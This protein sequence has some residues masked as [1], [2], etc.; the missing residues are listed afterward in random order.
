MVDWFARLA[1]PALDLGQFLLGAEV[2]SV[3]HDPSLSRR[4]V[5]VVEV[6]ACSGVEPGAGRAPEVRHEILIVG[7]PGLRGVHHRPSSS[8][9]PFPGPLATESTRRIGERPDSRRRIGQLGAR[10]ARSRQLGQP[11]PPGR[12]RAPPGRTG[13]AFRL[14]EASARRR[15]V[16]A[17][18]SNRV[19][20]VGGRTRPPLKRSRAT[21]SDSTPRSR[22]RGRAAGGED[23][24]QIPWPNGRALPVAGEEPA[25][26]VPR[27]GS[28]RRQGAADPGAPRDHHRLARHLAPWSGA[29]G[30]K[31]S[32]ALPIPDCPRS[33]RRAPRRC[34]ARRSAPAPDR[35][36]LGAPRAAEAL[37]ATP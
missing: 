28:G 29:L 14:L 24:G 12:A 8:S 9:G 2:G 21:S 4:P 30:D 17:G 16:D 10:R 23:R 13:R 27:P 26:S 1:A 20:P 31:V 34:P 22:C 18:R 32:E 11:L 36:M 3:E 35:R 5:V 33:P 15:A 19:V 25:P 37:A 7:T 6:P